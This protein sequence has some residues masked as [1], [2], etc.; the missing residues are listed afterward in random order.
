MFY[1][2]CS[3]FFNMDG[4]NYDYEQNEL[5]LE[6]EKDVIDVKI[7]IIDDKNFLEKELEEQIKSITN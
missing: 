1:S 6:I 2:F 7:N 5:L 4:V 3:Y